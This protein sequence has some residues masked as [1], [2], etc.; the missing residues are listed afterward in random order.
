MEISQP[1]K[2][3]NKGK[4]LFIKTGLHIKS[5]WNIYIT[6]TLSFIYNNIQKLEACAC[7]GRFV[8]ITLYN[9]K[10]KNQ[11]TG[12]SGKSKSG[13]RGNYF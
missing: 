9:F 10:D 12:N 11:T 2:N 4:I 8:S 1:E 3:L 6:Q 7:L 5:M 13:F